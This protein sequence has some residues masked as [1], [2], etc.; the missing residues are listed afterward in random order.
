MWI[1]C[2]FTVNKE[3]LLKSNT[4]S[5]KN[6]AIIVQC[7]DTVLTIRQLGKIQTHI[8]IIWSQQWHIY[9]WHVHVTVYILLYV[10]CCVCSFHVNI[11]LICKKLYMLPAIVKYR[12]AS[13]SYNLNLTHQIFIF[14]HLFHWLSYK[15]I[16]LYK[17]SAVVITK[18]SKLW[19]QNTLSI[20][21]VA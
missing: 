14:L 4:H 20:V 10:N 7:I 19:A 13:L 8:M 17:C 18:L 9:I 21:H 11:V 12:L 15:Y 16:L 3:N 5:L 2:Q 6:I 1:H